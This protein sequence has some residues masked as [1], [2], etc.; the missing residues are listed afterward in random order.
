MTIT[1]ADFQALIKTYQEAMTH[2]DWVVRHMDS[3][4]F[5]TPQ[6]PSATFNAALDQEKAALR[7]LLDGARR[8][9]DEATPVPSE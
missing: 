7:D 2:R 5:Q 4:N 8:L 3:F 9:L 6:S 1:I